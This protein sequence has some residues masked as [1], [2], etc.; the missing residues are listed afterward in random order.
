[1]DSDDLIARAKG[2]TSE[3]EGELTP[4]TFI[5]VDG[6]VC[7]IQGE[8]TAILAFTRF[9]EG[10]GKREGDTVLIWNADGNNAARRPLRPKLIIEAPNME[11]ADKI[12]AE[13]L[14]RVRADQ[15]RSGI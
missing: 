15:N 6:S 2:V 3:I 10:A 8:N 13:S 7:V 9:M 11:E 1:M 5:A 12:L 14:R 4:I